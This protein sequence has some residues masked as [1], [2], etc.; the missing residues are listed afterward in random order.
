[1][2]SGTLKGDGR[3]NKRVIIKSHKKKVEKREDEILVPRTP[4]FSKTYQLISN[5]IWNKMEHPLSK[6]RFPKEEEKWRDG[7]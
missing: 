5:P 3:V 2:N 4:G 7:S 1:M 6:I